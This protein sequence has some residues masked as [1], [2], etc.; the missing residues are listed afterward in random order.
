MCFQTKIVYAMGNQSF[1]LRF[2]A[3]FGWLEFDF[4]DPIAINCLLLSKEFMTASS[5]DLGFKKQ[6]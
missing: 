3:K 2:L 6:D 1:R 4:L 5:N